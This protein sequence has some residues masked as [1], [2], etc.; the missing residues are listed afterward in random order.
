[1]VRISYPPLTIPP[2]LDPLF[3]DVNIDIT[4][5]RIRKNK[6]KA[7]D[8]NPRGPKGRFDHHIE[9]A[10]NRSV[11]YAAPVFDS[12]LKTLPCCIAEVFGELNVISN[13]YEYNFGSV[14]VI[15][16]LK[17]LDLR[18]TGA[19]RAGVVAAIS[20]TPDR[21]YTQI[22]SRYFYDNQGLYTKIDGIIYTGAYIGEPSIML[23]DRAS[24]ALVLTNDLPLND[25][26]LRSRIQGISKELRIAIPPQS[27]D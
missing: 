25:P 6:Y 5:V 18:G 21:E 22:W 13:I 2:D 19:M 24:D 26:S 10:P 8:F 7:T 11:Y 4:L 1:L 12:M 17:L 9:D 14:R 27:W 23:Y 3:F 16:K 20:A 15:R